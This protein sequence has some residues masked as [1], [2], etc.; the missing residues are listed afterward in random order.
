MVLSLVVMVIVHARRV[1]AVVVRHVPSTTLII[2]GLL[3]KI[4]FQRLHGNDLV[5]ASAPISRV[6]ITTIT[7]IYSI[8]Y[9][10]ISNWV[11]LPTRVAQAPSWCR[12]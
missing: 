9:P 7:A 4:S 2:Y 11:P 10:A 1:K 3:S 12:T 8:L 5:S 6:V